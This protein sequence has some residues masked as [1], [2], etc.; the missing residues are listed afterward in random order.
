MTSI[1]QEGTP[2][3]HEGTVVL[4]VMTPWFESCPVM[5]LYLPYTSFA[6]TISKND[7]KTWKHH[8]VYIF[9]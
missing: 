5:G 7:G 2:V 6:A 9:W 4:L 1:V 3:S 8:L